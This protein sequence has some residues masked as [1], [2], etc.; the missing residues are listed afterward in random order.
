MEDVFCITSAKVSTSLLRH[1]AFTDADKRKIG[2]LSPPRLC[3]SNFS[4]PISEEQLSAT[5]NW[6]SK[7]LEVEVYEKQKPGPTQSTNL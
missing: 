7:D 2:M 3:H 4:G 5:R 1:G 6:T